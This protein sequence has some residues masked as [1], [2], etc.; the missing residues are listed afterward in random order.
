[1]RRGIGRWRWGTTTNRTLFVILVRRPRRV[2]V[3]GRPCLVVRIHASARVSR[4]LLDRGLLSHPRRDIGRIPDQHDD[5]VAG[6]VSDVLQGDASGEG[7]HRIAIVIWGGTNE[8][9]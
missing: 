3:G 1:M 7:V 5:T 4:P 2:R 8:G 6:H 9:V